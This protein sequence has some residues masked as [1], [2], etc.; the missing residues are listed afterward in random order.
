MLDINI[1]Q[2]PDIYTDRLILN[3]I[4]D[5][6]AEIMLK[7]R[8]DEKIMFYIDRPLIQSIDEALDLI[9]NINESVKKNE[10][11]VWAMRLKDNPELIGTI[12]F[13][14]LNKEHHRGEVGYLMDINHWGKGLMQEAI[15]KIL[16]Y[17]FNTINF[18]SIEG[19]VNPDNA[20]S[21]KVLERNKFVREAYYKENYYYNGK[22]LDSGVY[23]LL[24]STWNA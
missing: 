15:E 22:F 17:G 2:I 16:D 8:S 6:D 13:W 12:G 18:H 19:V 5:D 20:A 10:G 11:F 24:K 9:H 23:S 7:L 21:I 3:A 4:T 1:G 14:R